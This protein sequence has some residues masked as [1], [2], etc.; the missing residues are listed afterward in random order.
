MHQWRPGM[1]QRNLFPQ[2]GH[3]LPLVAQYY[4]FY[5]LFYPDCHCYL[6]HAIRHQESNPA[7]PSD[8]TGTYRETESATYP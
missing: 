5:Y 8:S 4:S 6:Y 1:E 2:F 7:E 3:R